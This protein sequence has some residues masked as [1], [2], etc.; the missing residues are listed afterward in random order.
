MTVHPSV[1]GIGNVQSREARSLP[2]ARVLDESSVFSNRR[3]HLSMTPNAPVQRRYPQRTVRCNRCSAACLH[4]LSVS[5]SRYA[6][7][8]SGAS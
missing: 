5:R 2:V 1:R 6:L 4:C 8:L 7:P 3:L